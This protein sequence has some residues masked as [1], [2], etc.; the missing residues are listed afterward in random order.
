[1][2][3]DDE[4]TTGLFWPGAERA[5]RRNAT[6]LKAVTLVA[7]V[8]LSIVLSTAGIYLRSFQLQFKIQE[9]KDY[10]LISN[11]PDDVCATG[12]VG[13]WSLGPIEKFRGCDARQREDFTRSDKEI[14]DQCVQSHQYAQQKNCVR[15]K[16]V[17]IYV[18]NV[19]N[20]EDVVEG[21]TPKIKEVG[22]KADGGPLV[23]YED[24]KTFDT[25]FGATE[26]QFSEN[27]YYTYKFPSTEEADLGQKIVTPNVGLMEAIG[28]SLGKVDYVVAVV[29]GTLGLDYMNATTTTV[30]D[31]IRGQLLSFAWPNNFGSHFLN[32]FSQDPSLAGFRAKDNARAL[33]EMVLNQK[34][35]NCMVN[36]TKYDRNQCISMANTLVIYSKL[37]YESFQTYKVQPYGLTYRQGAGLFVFASVGDLI[38]Y[39]AGHDDPISAYMFPRK[40]SWNVVR[41]KTQVEVVAS[42]RAGMADSNNGLANV[43]PIGRSSLVTN[44]IDE[45]GDFKNYQ[46]RSYI[47]E[48]DWPG[49]RPLAADGEVVVPPDGPYPPQCNGGTPLKVSG[50]RGH[51]VK[52]RVWSLQEGVQDS[53]DIFSPS[54]MRPFKYTKVDDI[55][56][57]ADTDVVAVRRFELS[58][59]G[60]QQARFAFNCGE[61]YKKM[62][63]A[64]VLNR[65]ADCDEPSGMFNVEA[66]YNK[67][68]YVW[69][70]PHYYQVSSKDATQH[71]RSNLIGLVTPTGP[72]YQSTVLIEIESG[73]VLQSLTK[74]QMSIRLYKDSRNFFFTK[75]KPVVIPL[76]WR[77]DTKNATT[78]EMLMLALFQS[79]FR[80]L[81]AGFIACVVLG[82]VSLMAAL[83]VGMLLYRE[84]SLQTV[85]EKRKKIQ[86]ELAAAIPPD[87]TESRE[88]EFTEETDFM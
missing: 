57:Q 19:T 77:F 61:V 72:R 33:F 35:E 24:C 55:E 85:D 20:P 5:V 75:H 47:T 42:I 51:Q 26:A 73:R 18:Y 3:N 68:P 71:P 2:E 44:T 56:I 43:G 40:V 48:F 45:L 1:M 69:S 10:I 88:Q 87:A 11:Q 30:E 54:L 76:Y 4:E 58:E 79:S 74:E 7:F 60:L 41:S 78:A 22:R 38:G 16:E 8:C 29:W 52:P 67:I 64:G 13:E 63:E 23:F 36:G 59:S 39:Y 65:G 28:N 82:A 84:N 31:Y 32:D 70:L 15:G 9:L 25:E 17:R 14:Y 12:V 86:A 34:Q 62:S 50:S 81:H 53:V 80:G 49:C 66:A 27:C 37:Y 21:L 6:I 46:G 83:F